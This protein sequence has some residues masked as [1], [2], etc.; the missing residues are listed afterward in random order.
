MP[1]F[2]LVIEE[3]PNKSEWA[4]TLLQQSQVTLN[5]SEPEKLMLKQMTTQITMRS[6][7]K[8]QIVGNDAVKSV[9]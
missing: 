2:C 5:T 6:G 7:K 3:V 8:D 1:H 9:F 4:E